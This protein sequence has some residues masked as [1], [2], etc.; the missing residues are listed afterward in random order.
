[1]SRFVPALAASASLGICCLSLAAQDPAELCKAIG[2]VTVGQW[3]SYSV[4]GASGHRGK[5][6]FAIVGSERRRDT[7]L[8]WF[9]I[10][11][12]GTGTRGEGVMQVLVPGLGVEASGI[13][14]MVVKTAGQPAMKMPDQMLGMMN[15]RMAENNPA[16]AITRRCASARAVGW[17]TV[18]VPAGSVKALH[19]KDLEGGEAWMSRDI[20]FGIVKAHSKDGEEL[21]LTGRGM[22]AKSSITEKPMEMPGIMMNPH[23]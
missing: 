22:D 7:T 4:T 17:E 10:S 3:A 6:R 8:Y 2:T 15:Q 19:M 1:M 21:V 11:G 20:P 14:G 16:L 23:E 9:E 12:N 5:A 13:H 18:T